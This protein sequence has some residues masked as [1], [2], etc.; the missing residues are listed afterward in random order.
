MNWKKI[1]TAAAVAL[2][3]VGAAAFAQPIVQSAQAHGMMGGYGNASASGYGMGP[4]MMGGYGGG[5]GMGPGMMGGYGGGYGMGPGMMGGYG[6]YHMGGSGL[7][8]IYR[9]NLTDEQ[10]KQVDGIQEGL[11]KKN[12]DLMGKMQDE[13]SKLSGLGA[14][15]RD[16]PAILAANKRMFELRQQMLENRLDAQDKI[17]GLLTPQQKEQL[18]KFAQSGFD[19]DDY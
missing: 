10:R 14:D 18:Q 8:P 3:V 6:G 13:A 11:R 16:R 15:K 19:N 4:G 17:E 12:W 1:A 9:L 7:G 2:G 5:Y